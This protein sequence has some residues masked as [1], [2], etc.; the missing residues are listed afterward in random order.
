MI[1]A[2]TNNT[3]RRDETVRNEL[4]RH[5]ED[6]NT[7]LLG[8]FNCVENLSDVYS[9]SKNSQKQK[10]SE[11]LKEHIRAFQMKDIWAE[12]N[13]VQ[14]FTRIDKRGASRIDRIYNQDSGNLSFLD[15]FRVQNTVSEEENQ[16]L[17]EE[18]TILDIE[19]T[20]KTLKE[21]KTPGID[22]LGYEFYKNFWKELRDLFVKV[23]NQFINEG[24]PSDGVAVI[25]LIYKGGDPTELENR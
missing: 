5:M 2:C 19:K 9:Q 20:I 22:G 21:G 18:I 10:A 8:D 17:E 13:T 25:T 6:E 16:Y 1:L 3:K 14:G 12:K 11:D 4:V 23:L 15:E 7:V 24:Y